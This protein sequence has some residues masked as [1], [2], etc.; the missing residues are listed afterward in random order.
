LLTRLEANGGFEHLQRRW[1]GSR[2]GTPGFAEYCFD[3]WSRA[4]H[5]IGLLQ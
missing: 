5:A 3:F 1:I 2:L 4:D